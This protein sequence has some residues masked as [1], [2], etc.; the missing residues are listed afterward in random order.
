MRFLLMAAALAAAIGT[1]GAAHAQS[2]VES[3]VDRLEREM[4]AVQRRVFPGGAGHYFEPQITPQAEQTVPGIPASAPLADL[5]QRVA[6]LESQIATLTGQIEQTQFRLR[7]FEESNTA[8]RNSV[9]SRLDALEGASRAVPAGI[10]GTSGASSS[11]SAA[12]TTR[13]PGNGGGTLTAPSAARGDRPANAPATAERRARVAAVERPSTGDEA[14]DAYVYG[15]RLWSAKLYPE[16]RAQLET[17]VS[18]FPNHRRASWAQNL[19]GRAYLD[20]GAPSMAAVAFY[21][22]FRNNPSGERAP[23]SLFFLAQALRQMNQPA[24]EV[25]KVYDE[26]LE[27]YGDRIS[28]QMRTQVADGRTASRC[29]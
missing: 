26:L 7:Q 21:D 1:G 14:E 22:N 24:A 11:G 29:R 18:R 3:R 12:T 8:F 19:L 13:G 27:L 20:D 28:E 2:A 5:T 4:R 15:Y 25:C 23:D 6:A 9:G 16:A 10:G 17:V